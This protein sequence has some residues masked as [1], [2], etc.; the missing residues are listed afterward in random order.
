MICCCFLVMVID[1]W[2]LCPQVPGDG[3]F[4]GAAVHRCAGGWSCCCDNRHSGWRRQDSDHQ[5]QL[6]RYVAKHSQS[7]CLLTRKERE[8]CPRAKHKSLC[9][10]QIVHIFPTVKKIESLHS[11]CEKKEKMDKHVLSALKEQTH[12]H[13]PVFVSKMSMQWQNILWSLT[14]VFDSHISFSL[15]LDTNSSL[16]INWIEHTFREQFW[17][18]FVWSAICAG[19]PTSS[20]ARNL[21]STNWTEKSA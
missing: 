13:A 16:K 12:A 14:S 2:T 11:H 1:Q 19:L 15:S 5:T 21:F 7:C 20:F 6:C 18:I 10:T 3:V 9:D 4:L 17:C 8:N